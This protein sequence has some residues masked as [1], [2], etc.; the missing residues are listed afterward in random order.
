MCLL[1]GPPPLTSQT[2]PLY[3]LSND[4]GTSSPP[5]RRPDRL[6]YRMRPLFTATCVLLLAALAHR[7]P[8]EPPAPLRPTATI[9]L[10]G[11]EGRIDHM[12]FDPAT[13][14][15]FVA[16]L[17]NDTVEVIDT[18]TAKPAAR[19]TGP[20]E[21]QGLAFLPD[22]GHLVVASGQDAAV[23]LYGPDLKPLATL[24]GLDDAD[25]VRYDPD[26]RQVYVGY[27][28]GALAVIDPTH[29]TKVADVKLK[30]HPESFQLERHGKRIFVNV[31]AAHHVAVVDR[32]KQAVI[33]TWPLHDAAANFPMAFDEPHHRLFIACRQP[34][35]L[36][37]L[38]TETGKTV[39]TTDCPGDADDLFYDA[40]RARL[41]VTG[42][43]G[44]VDV[45]EQSDPDHY[46]PVARIP[47]APGARTSFFAAATHTLFVAVPHRGKQ[48]AELL[49]FQAPRL[50]AR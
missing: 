4:R 14:R 19:I 5:P 40:D 2:F 17:G 10:P 31:P 6:T 26:A 13:G 15:L 34:A 41:Y 21:P 32:E 46:R 43:E 27:G 49:I 38:D 11:V 42:G 24:H 35:K 30:G 47:T 48:E 3:C 29:L 50:D 39:A 9:P 16:A 18:K 23:R 33:T 37:V 44:A 36:L 12:A 1:G 8:A 25:N 28:D 45:I 20:K 7:A 22:S